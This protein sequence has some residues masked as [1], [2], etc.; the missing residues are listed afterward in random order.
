ML[1]NRVRLEKRKAEYSRVALI[2]TSFAS[3]EALSVG[4]SGVQLEIF[5]NKSCVCEFSFNEY[6]CILLNL[7]FTVTLCS[8]R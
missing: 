1:V 6:G 4:M 2:T 8:N 5:S 3:I 7:I